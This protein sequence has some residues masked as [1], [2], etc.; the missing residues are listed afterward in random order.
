MIK[1]LCIMLMV[2]LVSGCQNLMKYEDVEKDSVS[3]VAYLYIPMVYDEP[4]DIVSV[5]FKVKKEGILGAL[6]F[7]DTVFSVNHD[8]MGNLSIN[9]SKEK[10]ETKYMNQKT[11][12]KVPF[13][14]SQ[15]NL[16]SES[17]KLYAYVELNGSNGYKNKIYAQDINIK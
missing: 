15:Y 12:V 3:D 6:N 9:G 14:Y 17:F 5:D 7:K 10:L 2:I 8:G 11:Y 16:P 4:E 13:S 1:N